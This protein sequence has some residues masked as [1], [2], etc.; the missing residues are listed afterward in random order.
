MSLNLAL[1]RVILFTHNIAVMRDFYRDVIGLTI[2]EEDEGWVDFAAGGCNI[3]LHAAGTP[4]KT[5]AGANAPHKLV[6]FAADVAAARAALLARG[7]PMKALGSD[8]ALQLCD[9]ADPDGN[10][11]QISNRA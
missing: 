6:F 9:G 5:G 4:G 2:L 7:V 11:I 3:A 10:R 1:R 8:G